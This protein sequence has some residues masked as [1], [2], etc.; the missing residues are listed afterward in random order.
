MGGGQKQADE[1]LEGRCPQLEDQLDGKRY[2]ALVEVGTKDTKTLIGSL[3]R[4][5]SGAHVEVVKK[6]EERSLVKILTD[7]TPDNNTLRQSAPDSKFRQARPVY[8]TRK[9]KPGRDFLSGAMMSYWAQFA[10]AGD[11]G[12]GRG[13][14]LPRWTAWQDGADKDT[15]MILDTQ[16]DGGLRMA[17]DRMTPQR[18]LNEIAADTRFADDEARCTVLQYI[19]KRY[20][21]WTSAELAGAP[22]LGCEHPH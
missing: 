20:A 19:E 22:F 16:S 18:L 13:G 11:P 2:A 4:N 7:T 9:N 21:L 12:K 17:Q 14:D 15:Y 10:H 6:D 5:L 8:Y 1:G 3:A